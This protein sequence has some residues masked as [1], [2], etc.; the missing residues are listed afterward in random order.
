MTREEVLQ[1]YPEAEF[2][3]GDTPP[4]GSAFRDPYG[5]IVRWQRTIPEG[6]EIHATGWWIV[7][8]QGWWYD[9]WEAYRSA[10]PRSA[11]H[12]V[13]HVVEYPPRLQ[14]IPTVTGAEN[15]GA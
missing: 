9:G 5:R 8:V 4:E 13:L 10:A 6:D 7:E 1:I 11:E 3:P 14:A 2:F 15:Q 12:S